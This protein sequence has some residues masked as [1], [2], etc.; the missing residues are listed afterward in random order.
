MKKV[1]FVAI[2]AL[3][4]WTVQAQ[5][6][7][8]SCAGHSTSASAD[9]SD[10]V[11]AKAASLDETIER[12]VCETS[13][14]VSYYRKDVCQKSGK[15]SYEPVNYDP[16]TSQF[17]NASPSE[18]SGN[19]SGKSCCAGKSSSGK[20]SCASGKSSCCAGKNAKGA[21][22]CEKQTSSKSGTR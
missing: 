8:H 14:K 1:L 4:A 3:G 5:S 17:V 7:K 13:G 18:M 15:V 16:E 21:G 20:T 2:L 9:I 10:D 12:R 22:A 19:A 6:A 11:I